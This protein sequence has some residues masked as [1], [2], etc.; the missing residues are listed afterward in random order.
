[1]NNE[2]NIKLELSALKIK[3]IKRYLKKP[4]IERLQYIK[5]FNKHLN[6]MQ[7]KISLEDQYKSAIECLNFYYSK[8]EN[9]AFLITDLNDLIKNLYE[10]DINE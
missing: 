1:M 2:N 5:T 3:R 4:I 8:T 7:N 10:D 9:R 6:N